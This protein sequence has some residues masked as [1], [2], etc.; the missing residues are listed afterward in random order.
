MLPPMPKL[1]PASDLGVR[2]RTP[3]PLKEIEII[4]EMATR[5][6]VMAPAIVGTAP[7]VTGSVAA[8]NAPTIAVDEH[9]F[10]MA[11]RVSADG[12]MQL[13]L[14]VI[15]AGDLKPVGGVEVFLK[16]VGRSGD[17]GDG[18]GTLEISDNHR[19]MQF[20]VLPGP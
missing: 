4:P 2:R 1:F 9:S 10:G 8:G 5:R 12:R 20:E 19:I 6:G 15:A 18:G 14:C 3:S 16:F 13:S 11:R 17:G 7:V